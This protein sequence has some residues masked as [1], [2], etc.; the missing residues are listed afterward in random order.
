MFGKNKIMKPENHSGD[1]LNIVEIF[2]T[3]Q[4][5]GPYAGTPALFIRLGGCNLACDFCDTEFDDFN[6]LSLT[7]ILDEL[8]NLCQQ[9]KANLVVITGGEPM[10][11][12]INK[13]CNTLLNQGFEVQIETNGTIFQNLDERVKIICSPKAS[14]GKFFQIRSDLLPKISAF[15]FIISQSK[16]PYNQLPKINTQNAKIYLQPMDEYDEDKN[17][18]N[19]ELAK[20]IC[21]EK[22]YNLSLQ[23]H[24]IISVK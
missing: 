23:I 8:Q 1:F 11:Q 24:K 22:G 12:P 20:K 3:F 9:I 21:L 14:N 18:K 16:S 7:E 6:Q 19:L 4:G 10:R 15:K 2:P 5:E 17:N 13:L